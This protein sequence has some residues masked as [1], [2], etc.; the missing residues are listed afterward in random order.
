MNSSSTDSAPLVISDDIDDKDEYKSTAKKSP[1]LLSMAVDSLCN[2]RYKSF[3]FLFILFILI[4]S[5]V[6]VSMLLKKM[7]G[8][9]DD[10]GYATPYGTVIQG[11]VLVLGYMFLNFFIDKEL[12]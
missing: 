8:A 6:F 7:G 2:I 4:T 5:D 9:V 11:I 10:R 3:I 12:I 1:T